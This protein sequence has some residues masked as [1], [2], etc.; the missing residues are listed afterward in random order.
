MNAVDFS[1][2]STNGDYA[3][4]VKT[5]RNKFVSEMVYFLAGKTMQHPQFLIL[6]YLL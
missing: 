3:K 4:C 6:R 1:L 2:F 5:Q